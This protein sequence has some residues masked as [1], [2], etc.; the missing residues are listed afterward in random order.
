MKHNNFQE[1]YT[2]C[3]TMEGF[4]VDSKNC[5]GGFDHTILE[6][7]KSKLELG[8][9]SN[10]DWKVLTSVQQ[11]HIRA[12]RK[13]NGYTPTGKKW[14][15]NGNGNGKGGGGGNGGGGACTEMT[16][17]LKNSNDGDSGDGDGKYKNNKLID[18]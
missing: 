5:N 11:Q 18:Y 9:Y 12:E 3:K 7:G 8:P 17:V 2:F 14:K 6:T 10:K 13:K 16:K 15:G 4:N 1:A